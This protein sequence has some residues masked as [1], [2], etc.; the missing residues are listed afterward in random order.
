ME[1]SE[2]FL[3]ALQR[4]FGTSIET[5]DEKKLLQKA[6]GF[7]VEGFRF[8]TLLLSSM[9]YRASWVNS[10]EDFFLLLEEILDEPI[11]IERFF[12]LQSTSSTMNSLNHEAS[13][14]L[15]LQKGELEVQ[16]YEELI[17][18]YFI[19][20]SSFET[21]KS[22]VFSSLYLKNQSEKNN[23]LIKKIMEFSST[24]TGP[25]SS[26]WAIF[27]SACNSYSD[28]DIG[29]T[30]IVNFLSKKMI[31]LGKQKMLVC[32]YWYY[33]YLGESNISEAIFTT[34]VDNLGDDFDFQMPF[35]EEFQWGVYSIE[36]IK[37]KYK[38]IND[39]MNWRD[40]NKK[41]SV[42]DLLEE[43]KLGSLIPL[44]LYAK[45]LGDPE[46]EI[47][48]LWYAARQ[49]KSIKLLNRISEISGYQIP[50]EFESTHIDQRA[51]W[52]RNR[53]GECI[54]VSSSKKL[55]LKHIESVKKLYAIRPFTLEVL[56]A[57]L[58]ANVLANDSD[59]EKMLQYSI[60][61]INSPVILGKILSYA[62]TAKSHYGLRLVIGRMI[63]LGHYDGI[64]FSLKKVQQYL[65]IS[66]IEQYKLV[67]ET[68]NSYEEFIPKEEINRQRF[69]ELNEQYAQ[70]ENNA[71]ILFN[72]LQKEQLFL[73]N[74]VVE[75]L[76]QKNY[77]QLFNYLKQKDVSSPVILELVLK[78]ALVNRNGKYV[79]LSYNRLV[80]E[81]SAY[82][83]FYNL[84]V[85][86]YFLQQKISRETRR[87]GMGN[88][89]SR[90]WG[91]PAVLE[92]PVNKQA[93][94]VTNYSW[95]ALGS[96]RKDRPKL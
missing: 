77:K 40:K 57:L 46:V 50:H 55:S 75:L 70:Y 19:A 32:F 43:N 14:L 35:N 93:F 5:I 60:G 61:K 4:L 66:D 3:G 22:L 65:N 49:S 44:A 11:S 69:N 63:L 37:G 53:L 28:L 18:L 45:E 56:S 94:R 26:F 92:N 84:E 34:L 29:D 79:I 15:M 51:N 73:Q 48:A 17:C 78:A 52:L 87:I 54:H 16:T 95:D 36:S 24:L 21:Q 23:D 89:V 90:V 9:G 72:S 39:V 96:S 33:T 59:I 74:E 6:K 31:E 12:E 67:R 58:R 76:N 2:K 85:E 20:P 7:L 88:L 27:Y 13:I 91:R 42:A 25:N 41:L 62:I 81:N 82:A 47:Y 1:K 38:R 71:I 8:E 83:S 68:I 30:T 86:P 64:L 10:K 80:E